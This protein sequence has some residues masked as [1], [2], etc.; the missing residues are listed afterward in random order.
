MSQK[1]RYIIFH[2]HGHRLPMKALGGPGI[3]TGLDELKLWKQFLPNEL[4]IEKLRTRIPIQQHPNNDI[5]RDLLRNEPFGRLTNKGMDFLNKKGKSLRSILTNIK[6]INYKNVKVYATNYQRTQL[7]VQELLNG[8]FDQFVDN[9]NNNDVKIPIIVRDI[10][11]CSMSYFDGKPDLAFS[12]ISKV[13]STDKFKQIENDSKIIKVKEIMSL[14]IPLI[15]GPRGFDWM[16]AFDYFACRRAHDIKIH[17]DLVPYE[18]IVKQHLINRYD[19]YLNHHE[20]F[21]NFVFPMIQD[22]NDQIK[23]FDIKDCTNNSP[24]LAVFSCH[25]VNILG[26]LY[27]LKA[28]MIKN[29]TFWPYYGDTIIL[30][31]DASNKINVYYNDKPLEMTIDNDDN[32]TY[33]TQKELNELEIRLFNFSLV[34]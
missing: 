16:A 26:L 17:D 14:N 1:K 19:V 23:E 12:L 5:P 8:L 7:S 27:A 28:K 11:S 31:H 10:K 33:I 3:L 34:T 25:D 6:N 18:N 20:K 29:A 21:G 24:C 22:I 32:R 30:E 2:R 13:Q 15:I 9:D 4:R